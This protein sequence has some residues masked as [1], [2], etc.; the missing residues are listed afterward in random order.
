VEISKFRRE[1]DLSY[2]VR[3]KDKWKEWQKEKTRYKENEE[4]NEKLI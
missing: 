2:K 1:E 4:D 3:K